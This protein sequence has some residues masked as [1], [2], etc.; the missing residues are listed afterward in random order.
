MAAQP[1]ATMARAGHT[2][3]SPKPT[4][5]RQQ[6]PDAWAGRRFL[7]IPAQTAR[8]Q[9]A[10]R[11]DLCM[12]RA[13][14]IERSWRPRAASGSGTAAANGRPEGTPV[15]GNIHDFPSQAGGKA[16]PYGIYDVANDEGWVSVGIDHDT[17]QL[18]AASILAW[19][20]NLGQQRFPDARTLTI[21]ADCGGSNGNRTRLWKTELQAF[22]DRT[23]LAITVCHFPTR[24]LEVEHIEHRLFSC[25]G[26]NWRGR[27]L[28]HTRP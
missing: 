8:W 3:R 20:E 10:G 6:S 28:E 19:W 18:A 16:I 17:S 27:P 1:V 4:P 26:I 9:L 15:E 12:D 11:V 7:P 5:G 13:T 23:G 14:I 22:A 25:I 24:H 21:T 2:S